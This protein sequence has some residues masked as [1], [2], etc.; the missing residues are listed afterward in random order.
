MAVSTSAPAE[1]IP[2]PPRIQT[3]LEAI[4]RTSTE[5]A[6]AL[7]SVILFGSVVT[8]G[9]LDT[10]SD[11]DLILVLADGTCRVDM[12][13]LREEVE[14][15]EA[16][17]GFRDPSDRPQS[18]LDAFAR[19]VTAN[20]RSFFICTRSDLLSGVPARLLDISPTQALFVDRVVMPSIVGS[21]ATVWGEDLLPHV[22]LPPIRRFDVFKAFF[23]LCNQLLLSAALFPLLPSAT[24]YAM[25]ALKRSV[26]SCYFCFHLHPASLD[27]EIEFFQQRLGPSRTL[28]ELTALRRDDRRS[29]GFVVRCL[30]ALVRL[31]LRTALDNPFPRTL[32]T[33]ERSSGSPS[34]PIGHRETPPGG[35][36]AEQPSGG[37]APGA[38]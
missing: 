37:T 1:A 29:F 11:V 21:A 13:R 3:Y 35:E 19:K 16:L 28:A 6:H 33:L 38:P 20:Q 30:P 12:Q 9:F 34:H 32:L 5:E 22:P 14:R 25:G 15:L 31:H 10:G 8:G 2:L 36:L 27:E 18:A 7:V 23:G 24:K 17:H 26:H 4:V